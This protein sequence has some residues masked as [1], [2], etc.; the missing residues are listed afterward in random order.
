MTTIPT[1]RAF[2]FLLFVAGAG[3]ILGQG[4]K[5]HI[6]SLSP[7]TASLVSKQTGLGAPKI[8]K[9]TPV[10]ELTISDV[11]K[12]ARPQEASNYLLAKGVSCCGP[13]SHAY[14]DFYWCC[15]RTHIVEIKGS[16]AAKKAFEDLIRTAS[17][18]ARA[19]SSATNT[20]T[21]T[22]GKTTHPQ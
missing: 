5:M 10:R 21:T 11:P 20:T 9:N 6:Y 13:L 22:T 16:P 8:P 15:D 14:D 18:S 3:S 1:V 12:N 17:V 4:V 19:G 7:Q 2:G